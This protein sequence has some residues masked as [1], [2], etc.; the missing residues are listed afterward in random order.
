[1]TDSKLPAIPSGSTWLLVLALIAVASVGA[2]LG[3]LWAPWL[4]QNSS[5]SPQARVQA[6]EHAYRSGEEP[7]ANGAR[8]IFAHVM[9]TRTGEN[10]LC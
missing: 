10:C 8:E 9:D 4:L 1:M 7:L 5:S 3:S 6:A 2:A